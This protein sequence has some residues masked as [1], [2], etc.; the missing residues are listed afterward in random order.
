MKGVVSLISF[1]TSVLRCHSFPVRPDR[2]PKEAKGY[3]HTHRH[4][5]YS[6]NL[7]LFIYI[8]NSAWP[9]SQRPSLH[10]FFSSL[11]GWHLPGYPP[12]LVLQVSARLLH[13]FPLRPD[14]AALLGNGFHSQGTTLRRA[15]TPVVGE[16]KRDWAAH[17]PHM[18]R[19]CLVPACVCSLVA[20]SLRVPTDP[21][22]LTLLVLLWV[23]IHLSAFNPSPSSSVKSCQLQCL[24]VTHTFFFLDRVSLCSPGCPVTH[25]VNQAGLKLRNL[26]ASASRML[27]LKACA[28]M[29]GSHTHF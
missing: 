13:P 19:G 11:R 6:L 29:P 5:C 27:E 2:E 17:L 24:A 16:P 15:C 4:T 26:P 28:T 21:G 7:Y 20:Q 22:W 9:H 12:I 14:K 8:P 25:S 23:P 3:I 10:P 18:C 1:L